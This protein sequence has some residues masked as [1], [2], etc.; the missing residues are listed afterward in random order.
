MRT[1]GAAYFSRFS[2]LKIRYSKEV[3]PSWVI[4]S[5][6]CC[7]S[8]GFWFSPQPGSEE[9]GQRRGHP[10]SGEGGSKCAV[11]GIQPIDCSMWSLLHFLS[12]GSG[13]H[14]SLSSCQT[15]LWAS[16]WSLCTSRCIRHLPHKVLFCKRGWHQRQMLNLKVIC[17]FY[18][19]ALS[20]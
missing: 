15:P 5:L 1:D 3:Y 8:S 17:E 20:L 4:A 9:G 14:F 18:S 12:T 19:A 13:C 2:D 11:W 6:H 10:S 16:H 7:T